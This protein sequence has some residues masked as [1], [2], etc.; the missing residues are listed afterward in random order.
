LD[1]HKTILE[2]IHDPATNELLILARGLGLRRILTTLLKIYDSPTNLV[3]LLNTDSTEASAIGEELGL[4]GCRRP[5]LRIVGYETG[6][7][8]RGELYRRGGLISVTSRVLVVDI[9]QGDLPTALVTGM[10]V[11]HAE[12][13]TPLSL[14]AFIVRLFREQNTRGFIKAFSDQPEHITSGMS[15][16]KTIMK[17]LQLRSVRIYPRFHEKV[18]ACLAARTADVVELYQPLTPAMRDIHNALLACITATLDEI[19]RGVPGGLDLPLQDTLTLT[20]TYSRSF[21]A[22]VRRHLDSVWHKVG[23]RTRAL[24][25]DLGVLGRVLGYLLTYDALAFHTY[26]E[27]LVATYSEGAG[28]VAQ[29]PAWMLTDAANTIFTTAKRRCYVL[30][31]VLEEQP[32]WELL[33]EVLEEIEAEIVRMEG[34]Y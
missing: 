33:V 23:P 6:K 20:A 22:L 18:K 32:K 9:L 25:A 8:E 5:G 27:T 30:T 16:L 31:P 10:L 1:F 15:P 4:L 14:E 34:A 12:R 24:V 26:L 7:K 29:K 3:L 13:V 28:G 11:L 2:E 19:G 21:D 17:E